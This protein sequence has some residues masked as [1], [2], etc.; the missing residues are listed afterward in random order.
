MIS[1]EQ[2]VSKAS[3]KRP[4]A[5]IHWFLRLLRQKTIVP[6]E[7]YDWWNYAAPVC[8]PTLIQKEVRETGRS[9]DWQNIFWD[10]KVAAA[11]FYRTRP[12]TIA[13]DDDLFITHVLPGSYTVSK[14]HWLKKISNLKKPKTENGY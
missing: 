8:P 4:I 13:E 12:A 10:G 9:V 6:L 7:P 2:L 1:F 5:L 11:I 14:I 3:R